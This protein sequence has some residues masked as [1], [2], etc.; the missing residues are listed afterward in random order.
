MLSRVGRNTS[1]LADCRQPREPKNY[2][3]KKMTHKCLSGGLDYKIYLNFLYSI[4][5]DIVHN[6]LETIIIITINNNDNNNNN[7]DIIM[8]IRQ[9]SIKYAN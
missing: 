1:T 3:I 4:Q 6:V 8:I 9:T 2:Q 7:K 5:G